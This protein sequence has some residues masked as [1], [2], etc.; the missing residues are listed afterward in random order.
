M[1]YISTNTKTMDFHIRISNNKRLQFV[2]VWLVLFYETL[3][4]ANYAEKLLYEFRSK[5]K[6]I[7]N[8]YM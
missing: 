3:L 4:R 6:P 7:A 2:L 5:I 1:E 8:K